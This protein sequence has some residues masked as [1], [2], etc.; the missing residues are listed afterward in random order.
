VKL[1]ALTQEFFS[2]KNSKEN[3]NLSISDNNLLTVTGTEDNTP[4]CRQ[5]FHWVTTGSEQKTGMCVADLKD[6]CS[7]FNSELGICVYCDQGYNLE[8]LA[9]N[10]NQCG[11]VKQVSPLTPKPTGKPEERPVQQKPVLKKP[12]DEKP[13]QQKPADERPVA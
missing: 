12:E 3:L 4:K 10:N 2:Q 9:S 8:R 13:V 5:G 7:V 6:N 11:K 1:P